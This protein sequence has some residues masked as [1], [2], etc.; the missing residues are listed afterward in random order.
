[1]YSL[2]PL[3]ETWL[4]KEGFIVSV[5]ANKIEGT[6]KTGIFSSQQITIFLEDYIGLCSVRMQGE[7]S[8]CQRLSQ[9]LESLPIQGLQ[10]AACR[11]CG[12]LVDIKEKQCP[13]CG[14]PIKG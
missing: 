1:M 6:K 3:I 9:Y 5:I 13:K 11:Y 12:T 10:T 8:I 2:T 7:P 4:E 14:A